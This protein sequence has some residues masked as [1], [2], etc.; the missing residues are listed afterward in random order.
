[1]ANMEMVK[2]TVSKIARRIADHFW[3]HRQA[4]NVLNN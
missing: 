2:N 3:K 1:M 4:Y